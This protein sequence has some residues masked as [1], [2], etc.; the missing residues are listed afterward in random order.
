[1]TEAIRVE[2]TDGSDDIA[3]PRSTDEARQAILETRGRIS[4]T[5][6]DIEDALSAKK[7]RFKERV[8]VLRPVTDRVRGSPWPAVGIAFAAGVV[9]SRLGGDDEEDEED[10]ED[11]SGSRQ[12][13]ELD[14]EALREWRRERRER[15]DRM[16]AQR[17]ESDAADGDEDGGLRDAVVGLVAR[18]IGDGFRRFG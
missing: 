18:V 3:E 16:R 7:A 2:R 5:L 14:G 17:Q 11:R 15:L 6:D 4:E 8:N 12:R 1:M 9:L 10:E 13:D